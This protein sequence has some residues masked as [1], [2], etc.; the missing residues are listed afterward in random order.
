VWRAAP[1][2]EAIGSVA[3]LRR[4]ARRPPR[5]GVGHALVRQGRQPQGSARAVAL[6]AQTAPDRWRP[7]RSVDEVC[8]YPLYSGSQLNVLHI[9]TMGKPSSGILGR[10]QI[11][12]FCNGL[13]SLC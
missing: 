11:K 8:V 1:G 10:N 6:G 3:A 4:V 5:H 12:R 7:G 2:A 9:S 13:V